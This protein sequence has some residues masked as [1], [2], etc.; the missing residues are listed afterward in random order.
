[1]MWYAEHEKHRP[2]GVGACSKQWDNV[3]NKTICVD[4]G[5]TL[6]GSEYFWMNLPKDPDCSIYKF[7]RHIWFNVCLCTIRN[8]QLCLA[9]ISSLL[10]LL[11]KAFPLLKNLPPTLPI[12]PILLIQIATLAQTSWRPGWSWLASCSSD[13]PDFPHSCEWLIFFCFRGLQS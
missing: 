5:R 4:Y 1:M 13:G 8:L 2:K 3:A 9:P 10:W 7:K 6:E 12:L 11:P